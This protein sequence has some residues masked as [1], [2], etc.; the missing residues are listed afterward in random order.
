[1]RAVV[2]TEPAPGVRLVEDHPEPTVGPDDVLLQVG[3]VSVCG[4][5]RE[6]YEWTPAAE[7]FGLDLP[8]VLGH[9]AAGTVLAVGER[10][11]SVKVGDL[12]AIET[13]VP[14]GHCFACRT[15]DAHNCQT[16]KIVAMH[17]DGAFA[18]RVAVPESVCFVLPEGMSVETGALLEPAGVAW[19]ALQRSGMAVAG[20]SVLVSGCGPI[21]LMIIRFALALGAT[22]VI[23]IEPNPFRRETARTLGATVFSPGPEARAH[24]AAHHAHRDGVDVAFE[25]SAAPRAFDGLFDLVRR[26]GIVVTIGHPAAP[27]PIDIAK[28]IN[29]R[30]ITLRGVF[31][32]RLWDTW[33]EL[34][35]FLRANDDDLDW[36][37]THHLPL[38]DL[39][40]VVDLLGGDANKI[41]IHPS[42]VPESRAR[43]NHEST[44]GA[45]R[46]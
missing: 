29:K 38:G 39:G 25:V 28:H 11:R 27:V 8:V 33:E 34:S 24:V 15:G 44:M 4:T 16:M 41:L 19:H 45:D 9:E 32:R 21:G 31:G 12:V 2:K 10:V 7:A 6:M 36:I 46:P 30:G 22:E 35:A 17:L 20:G 14:C 1:M 26:E 42:G 37:V 3:A 5:D 13:H 23:A 18:E 43:I 40:E